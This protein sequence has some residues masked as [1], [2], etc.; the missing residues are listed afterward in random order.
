M[1]KKETKTYR[2][3]K[4]KSGGNRDDT[5]KISNIVLISSKRE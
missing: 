5:W 4:K 3:K 2:G 1:G